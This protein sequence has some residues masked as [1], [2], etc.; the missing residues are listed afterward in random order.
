MKMRALT[1]Y[2]ATQPG[3]RKAY[4]IN[5]DYAYGHSWTKAAREMLTAERRDIQIVGG[6][7]SVAGQ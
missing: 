2:I 1:N 3:I 4:L 7:S 6:E 5:Q